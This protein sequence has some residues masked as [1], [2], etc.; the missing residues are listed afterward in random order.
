MAGGDP[1]SQLVVSNH[2]PPVALSRHRES[3]DLDEYPQ[4]IRYRGSLHS[5]AC[6]RSKG[7]PVREGKGPKSF[8]YVLRS[9]VARTTRSVK[10]ERLK[11]GIIHGWSPYGGYFAASGQVDCLMVGCGVVTEALR[12]MFFALELLSPDVSPGHALRAAVFRD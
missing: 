12:S 4:T 2:P 6:R 10:A 11:I 3:L 7:W 9:I 8:Y 1:P 5:R